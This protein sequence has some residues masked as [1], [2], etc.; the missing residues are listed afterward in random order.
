MMPSSGKKRIGQKTCFSQPTTKK[1][2][3][4]GV[5]AADLS[6]LDS[7]QERT[8]LCAEKRKE[9]LL[10]FMNWPSPPLLFMPILTACAQ[11]MDGSFQARKFII[12]PYKVILWRAREE[13]IFFSSGFYFL[14]RGKISMQRERRKNSFYSPFA[15]PNLIKTTLPTPTGIFDAQLSHTY[16]RK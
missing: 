6:L 15:I 11:W 14:K 16:S 12:Q 13:L 4:V 5:C 7:F 9:I 8:F 3:S 2:V 1:W 10:F